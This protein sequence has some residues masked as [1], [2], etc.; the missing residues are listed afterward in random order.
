[1]SSPTIETLLRR[2][3]EELLQPDVRASAERVAALLADDFLEFGSTGQVFNK[4]QVIEALREET[5]TKRSLSKFQ[6]RMLSTNIA[7]VTYRATASVREARP[8]HSLRCSVWRLS[9]DRWQMVFHQ[10]TLTR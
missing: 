9:N 4:Q 10:G 3:E 7:L 5:G 2:L 1:M 8:V 6:S